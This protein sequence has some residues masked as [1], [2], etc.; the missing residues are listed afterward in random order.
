V[1]DEGVPD[2]VQ[3]RGEEN[4][5]DGVLGHRVKSGPVVVA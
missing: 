2:R 5:E 3:E 1:L 4:E